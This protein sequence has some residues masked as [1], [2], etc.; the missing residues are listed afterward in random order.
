[1]KPTDFYNRLAPF[2]DVMTDWEARLEFEGP[3]WRRLFADY[4]VKSVLDA[5]CGTG[6]HAIE[7]ARWG[8]RAAGAD[9][10]PRMLELA[11]LKARMAELDVSFVWASF[12]D[13]PQ[14]FTADFDAVLCIGN[15]L[16]HVLTEDELDAAL[17]GMGAVLRPGGVLVVQN[18]NYDRRWRE[19]PR[20]FALDSGWLEGREVLVW[21][22]A[23]Y[24]DTDP[25]AI[26]FHIAVFRKGH[27]GE[28]TVEVHS[29]RQRPWFR[30]ELVERLEA[31]EMTVEAVYGGFDETA[32]EP[33]T[34]P[35][36]IL[37]ARR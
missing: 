17:R 31:A 22:L 3:F 11:R 20:F 8:L 9:L 36:I 34:S 21:R 13:L 32:F 2:F 23:D 5:A 16:P 33:L 1:M 29:T 7:F 10:S 25:P 27:R 35:D 24:H 19:R 6:G 18:L 12:A 15:S 30:N 26:T 14:H 28:W 37:V 4:E